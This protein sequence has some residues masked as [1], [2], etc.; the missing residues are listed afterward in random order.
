MENELNNFIKVF[1]RAK[2]CNQALNIL[3]RILENGFFI[4]NVE[5]IKDRPWMLEI[6]QR[7]W[8]DYMKSKINESI[9]LIEKDE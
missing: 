6:D 8:I 1:K 4:Y 9:E 5:E 7:K 3:K 2:N